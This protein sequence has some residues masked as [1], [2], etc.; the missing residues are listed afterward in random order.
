MSGGLDHPE[1]LVR[2]VRRDAELGALVRD[3]RPDP[4]DQARL[5]RGVHI[6]SGDSCVLKIDLGELEAVWMPAVSSRADDV[7]AQV[8]GHGHL[9]EPDR[10][11][12]LLADLPYRACSD[13]PVDVMGVM[14]AVARFHQ[15]AER[16]ALPTYPIDA[17]FFATYTRQAIAAGCPGP[18]TQVLSRIDR[19]DRWLRSLGGHVSGHGDVHFWNAV[20]TSPD[21]P[22]RLIDPI[23]R[24]AHWAWDAAY[25]QLTS[26]VAETPDLIDLLLSERRRLGLR[27]AGVEHLDEL[28]T[29]LL[30]LSS[31][32]WW[33]LLRARRAEVWWREQVE[34]NITALAALEAL[35]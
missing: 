31:L 20:S 19:A 6:A 1:D 33:A 15:V 23:P 12:L 35:K 14:R 18:A 13:R 16:L 25:A 2:A 34:R 22:W 7:V 5:F 4:A 8:L 17:E 11:W 30:G 10:R 21:G 32:L 29:V 9:T 3:L 24:T 27:V 26:G 28:R